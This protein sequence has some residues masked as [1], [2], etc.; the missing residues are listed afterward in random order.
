MITICII[1]LFTDT[2]TEEIEETKEIINFADANCDTSR[3]VSNVRHRSTSVS[4]ERIFNS[5]N[6]I[7]L[8]EIYQKQIKSLKKQLYRAT[9]NEKQA[10]RKVQALKV[11][12]RDLQQRNSTMTHDGSILRY[13]DED[14]Q[15]LVKC[16]AKNQKTSSTPRR[17]KP[18]LFKL[19][20]SLYFYSP[21]AYNFLRYKFSNALPHPKTISK[22][23]RTM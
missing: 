7:N 1:I 6:I 23:Y 12:V 14:V 5:P 13:L 18:S 16:G 20:L 11:V 15:E 3:D 9:Y 8:R 17:W 2:I 10:Q 4:P 22:W 21:K 19:A